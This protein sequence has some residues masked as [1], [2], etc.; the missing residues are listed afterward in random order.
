MTTED[1][2]SQAFVDKVL[3]LLEERFPWLGNEDDEQ[4]SGAD[5]VDELTDLH[6]SL[7]EE[8]TA[9]RSKSQDTDQ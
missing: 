8:R 1:S 2:P 7:T 9:D 4:V 5:T 3:E 6:R